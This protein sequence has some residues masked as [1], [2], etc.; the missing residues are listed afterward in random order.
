[1]PDPQIKITGFRELMQALR[2]ATSGSELDK[3]LARAGAQ[4]LDDSLI[5]KMRSAAPK[6]TGALARSVRAAKSTRAVSLRVGSEVRV[7]Y[8]GPINFGWPARNIKAQEFIY[9]TIGRQG[10]DW[11]RSYIDVL[12]DFLSEAF[13]EGKL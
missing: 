9:S 6:L 8:A 1:M 12:D 5:P 4:W 7:P 10:D 3:A 13:P 2:K 11:E